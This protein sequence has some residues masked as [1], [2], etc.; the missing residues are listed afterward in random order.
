MKREKR[1]QT[2]VV[3]LALLVLLAAVF[4]PE[5]LARYRDRAVLNRIMVQEEDSLNEGYRYQLSNNEKLYLLSECLKH[6][7]LP[8]SELDAMTRVPADVDYEGLMGSY[9]FVINRQGPSGKELTEE[10]IYEACNR[11]MG[12]LKERK[13]FSESVREVSVDAYSATLYSAIDVLEPQNNM[14]VWKIS[15]STIQKNADKANR[16]IEAYLDAD[17]GRMYGFYVRTEKTWAQMD[18]DDMM[19]QWCTYLSLGEKETYEEE[20]PLMETASYYRKYRVS[21]MEETYTVV[22]IGFYE[23]INEFFIKVT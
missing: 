20:N 21:G 6:Q 4:G 2:A 7:D 12:V 23:G 3:L 11:E 19:E 9:A 14:S 15:L 5:Q 13:I 18:P 10:Q 17:T 22:T 1:T 16:L 8:Q